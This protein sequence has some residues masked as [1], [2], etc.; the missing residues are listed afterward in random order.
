MQRKKRLRSRAALILPRQPLSANMVVHSGLKEKG[1][2]GMRMIHRGER[3]KM[4][5][6]LHRGG[7]GTQ[8]KT[9]RPQI[10]AD[11][12]RSEKEVLISQLNFPPL[13]ALIYVN[14]RQ[15]SFSASPCPRGE[16]IE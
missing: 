7:A 4:K 12:R 3:T 15:G 1:R 2:R 11:D 10:C 14:Q 5:H 6:K 9:R 16:P 13:S 8:R